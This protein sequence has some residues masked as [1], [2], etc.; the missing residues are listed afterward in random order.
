MAIDRAVFA[1]A[2]VDA[3][4]TRLP[5]FPYLR[6]NR[7]LASIDNLIENNQRFSAWV[8]R[9]QLL[10]QQARR[11]EL[12]NL[13]QQVSQE[14][15]TRFYSTLLMQNTS[16]KTLIDIV[17]ACGDMLR[18]ADMSDNS[19]KNKL[20]SLKAYPDE[21]QMVNRVFGIYPITALFVKLGV[22]SYQRE[23]HDTFS[24][25]LQ[26]LAVKGR[27]QHYVLDNKTGGSMLM[28]QVEVQKIMNSSANNV[29]DI[30]E[31]S[32][33]EK[34]RLFAA[35]APVIKVDTVDRYDRLGKPVWREEQVPQIDTDTPE[36]YTL[37]SHVRFG[38]QIL[39][40]LNY[41]MWF[42]GRPL[43]GTF[44]I[45]GGHIDGITWRVTIGRDG[46]P[47]IYDVM[48]NCGCYHMFFP[49]VQLSLKDVGGVYQEAPLVP[50]RGP[51]RFNKKIILQIESKT[52]YLQRVMTAEKTYG[53]PYVLKD[54]SLLRSLPYSTSR[55]KSLFE[56]NGIVKG[57]ERAERWLLWP[58]GVPEPGAMRQWG[59]HATAFLGRRHFDDPGLLDRYFIYSK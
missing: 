33:K 8:D 9:L 56:W 24:I 25:P 53:I 13:P 15:K 29:L 32:A 36:L 18:N 37:I 19:L 40:Q 1:A 10:D 50:Q 31:P 12:A 57:T 58:M 45:L 48:H 26:Q 55:R 22:N 5:G 38:E 3:G 34:Q 21:Y 14:L 39:L 35:F 47:L 23:T 41:I 44:D 43:D 28:P 54:Y 2:V 59:R 17:F 4:E 52:H 30:P 51:D 20:L 27:V 11:I 7:F 16:N 46:R 49:T 42:P 6:I